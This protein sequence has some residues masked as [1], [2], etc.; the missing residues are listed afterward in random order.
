MI[1]GPIAN[2][3]VADHLCRVT[4]CVNPH[5]I[6]LVTR[7]VN[8]QRQG[9]HPRNTSGVRGVFW[10]KDKG[11]WVVNAKH[12]GKNYVG[13]FFSLLELK[14]AEEAAIALRAKVFGPDAE[15]EARLEV[16]KARAA[17]AARRVT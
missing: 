17:Q 15:R 5:H 1:R 12:N 9:I 14:A 8:T 16:D 10:H 4:A 6:E 7:R 13:G 3:L 11:K 2:E